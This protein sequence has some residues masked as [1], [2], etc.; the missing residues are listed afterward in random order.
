MKL[1]SKET[2]VLGGLYCCLDIPFSL[3]G[4]EIISNML[5][6]FFFIFLIMILFNKVPNFLSKLIENNPKAAYYLSSVGW[7]VYFVLL[8]FF[9]FITYVSF[10]EVSPDL[11]NNFIVGLA[12]SELI[13]ALVSLCVAYKK[14][15]N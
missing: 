13:L 10:F 15:N 12:C 1:F 9:G 7:I 5:G 14:R 8:V 3:L 11:V 2:L 4:L 6:A